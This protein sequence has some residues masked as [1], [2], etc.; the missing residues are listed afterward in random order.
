LTI[1]KEADKSS[2]SSAETTIFYTITV[3]NTGNV[4]LTN[5][6]LT[7]VFA[8]GA[9]LSSGDTN[10]NNVLDV[11]EIWIYSADYE[12][13]QADIN[14]GNDLIN[15]ASVDT[16]QTEPLE[17]NAITTISQ[18]ASLT[19][20]KEADKS[21]VSSAETTINYTITVKNTG[22]VNLTNVVLT[23][24]FAGG[25][26]LSS[27]DTNSN[28]ILDVDEIWIY[29]ADYEVTQDDMD[30]GTDLVNVA[31]VE[32]D[33]TDA[34]QASATTTIEQDGSVEI[35]KEANKNSVSQAGEVITYSYRVINRGNLLLTGISVTDDKLGE[36]EV[37]S[38]ILL[39][40]LSTEGTA[41]YTVTQNDID[42]GADIVNVATVTTSQGPTD[43]DR[44]V[45]SV[46]QS[47]SITIEKTANK[48]SVSRAGEIITYTYKVTNNGN[49]T[50]TGLSAEDNKLGT[51][52]FANEILAPGAFT[53]GT[54]TYS[55]TQSDMNSGSV[56][57][58][59]TVTAT[60]PNNSTVSA[61]ATETVAANQISGL[62]VS[63]S[64]TSSTY[65]SVG[66][67]IT[68]TIEVENTGNLTISDIDVSD[69]LTGLNT[70]IN[71]LAPGEIQMYNVSYS[72]TQAD[73]NSGSVMN[74]ASASGTDPN[75]ETLTAS[76]SETVTANQ[77]PGLTVTKNASPSSY[78]AVGD[79]ITYTIVVENTGNI[80]ISD[81]TIDDPLTGLNSTINSLQP[82]VKQTYTE[83]YQIKQSDLNSGSVTN[84]ASASG[85]DPDDNTVNASDTE[86]VTASQQSDLIVTKNA[87]SSAYS[88][89]GEEI[90]YTIEVENTGNVT[91]V[92][93]S[94]TDPLTGMAEQIASLPPD[95]KQTYIETYIITLADMNSGSVT[96]TASAE[97]TN[98]DNE[99]VSASDVETITA[100]QQPGLAVTK[101]ATPKNYTSVGDEISFSIEV[102][103][104]GNVTISD[105]T[106]VDSLL[107]FNELVST[108][109]PG[110]SVSFSVPYFVT[111]EDLDVGFV[112][113]RVTVS[114]KDTNGE[115]VGGNDTETVTAG[116]QPGLTVTKTATPKAYTSVGD[117]ISFSI[118]V[119]NTGNVSVREILVT[120][121]L[122][123]LN[124]TIPG[125]APGEEK[126][127]TETYTV[128]QAD[129]NSG[130]V[131]NTASA[132]GT[133]PD[134]S[135]VSS[136][137]TETVTA[138][139]QPGLTVTK[140]ATPK[141]Y[142]SVGDEINFRIEVKNTGNV[143][144]NEILVTDPLTGLNSTIPV[145]AP[146]E[147][148]TYTET[149]TITQADLNSGSV[150]NTASATGTTPDNSTVSSADTEIVTAGQQPGLTVT[151]TATPKAYTSVGDEI[152]FS[153][154]VE[155]TGNVS[156]TEILV[157]DPLTG[158]NSTI[159]GLAPGEEEI[160][161]ETYIITQ[162]DLNSGSVTNTASVTGTTP[163]N[164]SV[165]AADT[166]TVTAG[167]QSGLTVT[168]TATPNIYT[169]VGD[170]ISFFIEVENTGNVS[171]NAVSVTD[172]LTG[173]NSTIPVLA[174]G[175]TETYTEIYTITQADLN[176]GSV[177]NT[178]TV[179]GLG[180]DNAPVN[181]EFSV[182]VN[183]LRPPVAANDES[184][185]NIPGS[186]V[187]VNILENDKLEDG[188][189]ALSI[190]VVVDVD[191]LTDGIQT[192]LMVEGEGNWIFDDETGIVTFTPL[193]TFYSDPAPLVYRLSTKENPG[194]FSEATVSISVDQEMLT[195]SIRLVKRGEYN[196]ASG[197]IHYTFEVTNTGKMTLWDIQ[198][199]DEKI[200]ITGLELVPDTLAPGAS[201]SATATYKISQADID[202]GGVTNSAK[203][204]SFNLR[205]EQV[206]DDSGTDP[207]N[208]EPTVTTFEQNPS[209]YIEKEAVLFADKVV[210][211]EEV[212]FNI[213]IE[214]TGNV[215]LFTVLVEDPLTGFEQELTQ[216]L[217]GESMNFNTTYTVLEPDEAEG[218]FDNVAIISA[219]TRDGS[220]IEASST[221][222]VQVEQCELVIPTGF[223]PNDDG[224]Q[225][226]WRITCLESYP[227]ARVEIYNRWGNLVFE[228][229]NFGNSDVHGTDAWWDGY[230]SKKWTFGNDKLPAGTYFF[231]LDLNDGNEPLNGHLFLNR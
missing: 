141:A 127:Y 108:L 19:I 97:G 119:E 44:V 224:I 157:T 149:Y 227:D 45:V 187:T 1:T 9:T 102:E 72:I 200:G 98:P 74:T 95:E 164:S 192:E 186:S 5:V 62:T 35:V 139:Q 123:G 91:L 61:N 203:V 132:S 112:T 162:A 161:T 36:I 83:T 183:A 88:S 42:M 151:K 28:N 3:K 2:V 39:L 209:V 223:S 54:A 226:Y 89:A 65:S 144:V 109:V 23:D 105:I 75:N 173:L 190:L 17:D 32:T 140:T 160:Y 230:S 87:G 26:T 184:S 121:P 198:I 51:I 134:N 175:E 13:T 21:S 116:Q 120:D 43:N 220:T 49:T 212:N 11:D 77:Q 194:L 64:A 179:S 38:S 193:P 96:N 71:N 136:T 90:T 217:P 24:V 14:A 122:T 47:P 103:N 53:E 191:P 37:G 219:S 10:S 204:R 15:V 78:S 178:V 165:S 213:S 169:S 25:A 76:D 93:V 117:E 58:T 22:N 229:D 166:E 147:T 8:G 171:V 27:G 104:T 107:D 4:N 156:V 148:E 228:K 20:T 180:P 6:V 185:D 197:T 7:D 154:K 29:S 100:I 59:V 128:T 80:T 129:L 146:G 101:T 196:P 99:T 79:V 170:E 34:Q 206:G 55:V 176:S 215:T 138:G 202:A 159:P 231:I 177:T 126:I 30:A 48:G 31:S 167:Q 152:S 114:G 115:T 131:T 33:Q 205:G 210:L 172:P 143:S 50:L 86:T 216:L 207:E 182:T 195:S 41:T 142:T 222:T 153:I 110:E 168:K 188:S 155:N 135:T 73:L 181:A 16:D 70:T 201:G 199:D 158:L 130:R 40:L 67:E 85:T 113:N 94:V 111:Q 69:P 137:D 218:Q 18:A 46:N 125:L 68:Y 81:I 57:N 12:V 133:T 221:V 174:P 82:G 60:A 150:T 52:S 189:P 92:N 214:N 63:K 56:A 106:L 84:T 225:D 163:D 124:S 66:E 208:D 211:G 145:L 118:K